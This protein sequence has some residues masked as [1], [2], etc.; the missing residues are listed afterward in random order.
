MRRLIL[1]RHAKSDWTDFSRPDHDRPLN[2]RGRTSADALGGWLRA[3]GY[4]ADE[5]LCSTSERTRETLRRLKLDAGVRTHFSRALYHADAQAMQEALRRAE[6]NCV[7]MVG[8]NPG[9]ADFA[10]RLVAAPPAHDRFEDYPTGATLVCDMDLDD[11]SGLGW[12]AGRVIDFVT[13]R[14]LLP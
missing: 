12:H 7:L 8:H 13:P 5:V 10:D 6:G 14:D 4:Q 1:M 9:I 11:W 2:R 3:R